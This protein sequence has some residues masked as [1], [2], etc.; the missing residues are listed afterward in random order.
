MVHRLAR[1][2]LIPALM[3]GLAAC[4]KPNEPLIDRTG[5]DDAR[6]QRDLATCQQP[7]PLSYVS[8]SNPVASCMTGKGYKVLMG[9]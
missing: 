9:R 3:G 6:Y 1:F 7:S 2:A 5:V 4:G 8:L